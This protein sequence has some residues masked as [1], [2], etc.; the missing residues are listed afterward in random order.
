MPKDTA[1]PIAV[2]AAVLPP[3]NS[4]QNQSGWEKLQGNKDKDA[5]E[6]LPLEGSTA[7]EV[8]P[9]GKHMVDEVL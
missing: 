9:G 5:E 2:G 3:M 7:L 6:R 1:I 8:S 4:W